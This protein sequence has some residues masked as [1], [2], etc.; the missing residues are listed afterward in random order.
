MHIFTRMSGNYPS[1]GMVSMHT[2]LLTNDERE[3]P[4]YSRQLVSL[5]NFRRNCLTPKSYHPLPS[6]IEALADPTWDDSGGTSAGAIIGATPF[7]ESRDT[8]DVRCDAETTGPRKL[9]TTT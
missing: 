9:D 7:F 6:I 1:M 3:V 8:A 2:S 4:Q 5:Q